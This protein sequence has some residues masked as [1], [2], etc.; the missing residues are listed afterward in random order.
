MGSTLQLLPRVVADPRSFLLLARADGQ[1]AGYA[2]VRVMEASP[3]L[4]DS[5]RV[6]AVVAEIET[7]LISAPFRDAGLGTRLLNE[8]DAELERLEITE[9]M[10]GV[11]PG[12]DGAQR[13]YERRG[14]RGRWLLLARGTWNWPQIDG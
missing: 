6:P 10:V 12:N 1:L 8:I 5:W 2:L 7:M 9:V 14:F 13:L 3:E 11:M 4:T